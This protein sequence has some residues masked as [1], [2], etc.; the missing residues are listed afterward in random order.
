MN[1]RGYGLMRSPP[2]VPVLRA[3]F[4]L[5]GL[6]AMSQITPCLY[7]SNGSAAA[8]RPLLASRGITCVVNVT[9]ELP[10]PHWPDVEHVTVPL[11]DL[12]HAPLSLYFDTIADKVRSVS[13]RQGRTLIHCVAGI[14]RSA[15]L[16]LAYLI[17]YHQHS[18]LQAYQWV[19]ARR[20]IIRPNVGFWRQLVEYERRV[21]GRNSVKMVVS[22]LG[23]G[24]IPQV[25]Q[26]QPAS[27]L[28]P[29]WALR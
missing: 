4:P 20:P 6:A 5:S 8:N 25:S 17:K 13:A 1:G 3:G 24:L 22:G 14:S 19:K 28:S 2:P 26:R 21:S 16:C 11:P 15:S 27:G 7:L 12:P 29:F 10:S 9:V 23:L 18:L